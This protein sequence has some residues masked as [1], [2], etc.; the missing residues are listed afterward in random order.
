M[1]RAGDIVRGQTADT[2]LEVCG[3]EGLPPIA[4]LREGGN[5]YRDRPALKAA[6]WASFLFTSKDGEE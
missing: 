5:F 3:G 4:A 6:G 2:G 1:D